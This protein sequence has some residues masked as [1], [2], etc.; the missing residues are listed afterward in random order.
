MKPQTDLGIAWI[1]KRFGKVHWRRLPE[2][3]RRGALR[4][5]L[6][7]TVPWVAWYGY[8][9][10]DALQR[11]RYG[12]VWRYISGAV[13]SLLVVPIGGPILFSVIV[14]VAAGFRKS[15]PDR[16]INAEDLKSQ[17]VKVVNDVG[18]PQPQ[19]WKESVANIR[20]TVASEIMGRP[21]IAA[22]EFFR[23]G[24]LPSGEKLATKPKLRSEE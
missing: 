14:W 23:N 21:D 8:H 24:V 10:F 16:E 9:I 12:P 2:H 17:Q 3:L 1:W 5:Y 11:H 22:D 4:L 18:R 19:Q 20:N 6:V 13:G 15:G 7:V